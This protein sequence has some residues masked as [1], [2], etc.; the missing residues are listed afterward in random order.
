MSAKSIAKIALVVVA[1][2]WTAR[3]VPMLR[4]LVYGA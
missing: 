3:Q 1:V 2:M 4:A